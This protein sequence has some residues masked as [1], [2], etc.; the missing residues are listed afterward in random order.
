MYRLLKRWD[1]G[2]GDTGWETLGV[3]RKIRKAR[4][5]MHKDVKDVEAANCYQSPDYGGLDDGEESRRIS[6]NR[7]VYIIS[8]SEC[9]H[10]EWEITRGT[11][12]SNQIGDF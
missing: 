9:E 3:F 4:Q 5:A 1:V 11:G 8:H 7:H 2:D 6:K 12:F 10:I